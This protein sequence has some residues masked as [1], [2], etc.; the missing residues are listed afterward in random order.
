MPRRLLQKWTQSPS[1]PHNWHISSFVASVFGHARL[2]GTESEPLLRHFHF[3]FFFFTFFPFCLGNAF[4]RRDLVSCTP[5][6]G[7][8]CMPRVPS[9]LIDHCESLPRWWWWWWPSVNVNAT[10]CFGSKLSGLWPA[11]NTTQKCWAR[12]LANHMRRRRRL[13]RNQRRRSVNC[14]VGRE[15]VRD[16]VVPWEK[17]D[18]ARQLV[19]F[20]FRIF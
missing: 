9:W 12:K 16:L 13:P 6:C 19:G 10:V 3:L 1:K 11:T 7:D 15:G 8:S 17:S 4:K 14:Q 2:I 5:S 18:C 20:C